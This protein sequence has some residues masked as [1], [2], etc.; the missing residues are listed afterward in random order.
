VAGEVPL[1]LPDRAACDDPL[2]R[3][4]LQH[5]VDEEKGLAVRKD[6]LDLVASER[7][8]HANECMET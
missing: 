6:R 7:G 5:L 2:P 8:L 4:E 1:V 3:L